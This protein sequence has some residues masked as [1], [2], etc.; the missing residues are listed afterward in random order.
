MGVTA[1]P[2]TDAKEKRMHRIW[3]T[4]AVLGAMGLAGCGGSDAGSPPAEN[5]TELPAAPAPTD[6]DPAR[7]SAMI[8]AA[9]THLF[10]AS[11]P[12]TWIVL[13]ERGVTTKIWGSG[14]CPRLGTQQ[15]WVDRVPVANATVVWPG[16]RTI[17]V[18][19][20]QCDYGDLTGSVLHGVVSLQTN[21]T[22]ASD[23]TVVLTMQDFLAY[24]MMASGAASYT[25]RQ[26][27]EGQEFANHLQPGGALINPRTGARIEF[28]GGSYHYMSPSSTQVPYTYVYD[29]IALV[30]DGV[31]YQIA[32]KKTL[33]MVDVG[34]SAQRTFCTGEVTIS[35][36]TGIL[37]ARSYCDADGREVTEAHRSLPQF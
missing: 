24:G 11:A 10:V 20:R 15:I 4:G 34:S 3:M 14:Y 7:A 25:N 21:G 22:S 23:T 35:D 33:R 12:L 27:P 37:V 17:D 2:P 1:E 31:T 26:T 32:G 28:R 18:N 5:A 30:L 36:G 29:S 19:F 8:G 16:A 6:F 9:A 13:W